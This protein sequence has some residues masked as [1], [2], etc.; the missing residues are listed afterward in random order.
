[1]S[2]EPERTGHHVHRERPGEVAPDLG[3]AVRRQGFDQ[4]ACLEL[5]G[6]GVAVG[7]LGLAQP[8]GERIAM[9]P[10][11]VAV[12]RQHART[13]DLCRGEPRI[14]DREAGCVAHDLDA[15]VPARDQPAVEDRHPRDG[16]VLAQARQRRVRVRVQL[17]ERQRRPEREATLDRGHGVRRWP[18][19]RRRRAGAAH[20]AGR[21][22]RASGRPSC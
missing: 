19:S 4:P 18:V 20:R 9:A 7:H 3:P 13:D 15:Q 16:L 11:L 17:I 14:V 2:R 8:P 5:D 21:S 22:P 1:M 6:V 10:M 12:E